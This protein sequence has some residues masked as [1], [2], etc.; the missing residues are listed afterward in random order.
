MCRY[1]KGDFWG[2]R[3]HFTD[4][5]V[6]PERADAAP[7][8]KSSWSVTA[9]ATG[10]LCTPEGSSSIQSTQG[11]GFTLCNNAGNIYTA[12]ILSLELMHCFSWGF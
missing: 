6:N 11:T 10:Q 8:S 2:Q 7:L 4:R 12:E 5:Q 9:G 3:W 1:Q